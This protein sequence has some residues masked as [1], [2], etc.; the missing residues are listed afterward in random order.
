MPILPLSKPF[1]IWQNRLSLA[2]FWGVGKVV[3]SHQSGGIHHRLNHQQ[4][5]RHDNLGE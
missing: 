3:F 1:E 5:Q 4:A 2:H